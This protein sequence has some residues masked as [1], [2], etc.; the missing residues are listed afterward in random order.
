MTGGVAAGR[1]ALAGTGG[2]LRERSRRRRLRAAEAS[3]P[4]LRVALEGA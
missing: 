3:G 1:V 2:R 4:R